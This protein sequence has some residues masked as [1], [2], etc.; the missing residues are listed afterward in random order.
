M[1][2][3]DLPKNVKKIIDTFDTDKDS[4]KE[5]D[6]IERELDEIGWQCNWGLDGEIFDVKP[7]T[8]DF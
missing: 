3:N 4:Y 6:R 8:I 2:Y 5:C 1:E 7:A